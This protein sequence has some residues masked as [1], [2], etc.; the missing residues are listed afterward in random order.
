MPFTPRAI[1]ESIRSKINKTGTAIGANLVVKASTADDDGVL[2]P[3]AVTDDVCG[4][5]MEA[6]ADKTY[7]SVQLRGLA[8]CTA[9]GTVTKG[10]RLMLTTAG[11]VITWTAAAGSNAAVVGT[12][13]RSAVLDEVFEVELAGPCAVRQG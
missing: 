10:D 2:L 12:A 9:G 4:V 8:L 11:K 13:N 7:G 1:P 3:A 6:I 5:T